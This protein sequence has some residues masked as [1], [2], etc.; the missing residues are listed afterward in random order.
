MMTY[1]SRLVAFSKP[2][3]PHHPHRDFISD[4]T[5]TTVTS[6]VT[7]SFEVAL[8]SLVSN[9]TNPPKSIPVVLSSAIHFATGQNMTSPGAGICAFSTA[10]LSPAVPLPSAPPLLSILLL[11]TH[12]VAMLSNRLHFSEQPGTV[13]LKS[14]CLFL[15]LGPLTS[16]QPYEPN[17][18][19]TTVFFFPR[20]LDTALL[21]SFQIS[22]YC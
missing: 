15:T 2:H 19:S 14:G 21:D 18:H 17:A 5:P 22:H 8:L 7:D 16:A 12:V 6:E 3:Q 4:L 20:S 1:F 9:F 10:T 11:D 13:L